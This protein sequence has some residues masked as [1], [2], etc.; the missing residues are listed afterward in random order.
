YPDTM[1]KLRKELD[2]E[3]PDGLQNPLEL[4]K[5]KTLPY[6]DAVLKEAMRIRP[7]AA[8]IY[9]EVPEDTSITTTDENGKE[10][11]IGIPKGTV[12]NVAFY[13]MHNSPHLWLRPHEFLP[14]RW[15][16]ESLDVNAQ[17]RDEEAWGVHSTSGPK[18][19]G[20]E[21]R[22]VWGRP[23]LTNKDAF[24]AFSEG[25]RDCIGK[26]FALNEM[27]KLLAYLIRRFDIEPD[28]D[29]SENIEGASLVTLTPDRKGGLPVKLK[30]RTD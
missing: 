6:L 12:V 10:Q 17:E 21:S 15:L 9:R 30:L 25:S 19:E 20:N 14:E 8:A 13:T 23:K 7:V 22:A 11:T 1:S 28:Y 27:R 5:L 18:G 2:Q 24:F 26:N 29:T 4:A 16:A 3:F